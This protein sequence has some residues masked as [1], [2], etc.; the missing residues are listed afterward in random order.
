MSRKGSK[1]RRDAR[2]RRGGRSVDQS[3]YDGV[4]QRLE[5]MVVDFNAA[6]AQVHEAHA[7]LCAV[8]KAGGGMLDVDDLPPGKWGIEVEPRPG[9]G[10]TI[11]ILTGSEESQEG[12]RDAEQN[13]VDRR[14]V[15]PDHGLRPN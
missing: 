8:V 4:A 13:T 5:A 2:K 10:G 1:K 7:A 9:G 15:E 6:Q 12:E 11:L 14:D 3:V